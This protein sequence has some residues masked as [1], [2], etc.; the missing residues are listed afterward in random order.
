LLMGCSQRQGTPVSEEVQS[1]DQ[2]LPFDGASDKGGIFP[3]RSLVP[4]AIPAGT[5][6][7]IHLRSPLSSATSKP[8]DS[9]EA[10]LDEAIVVR[11]RI[12]APVG[13]SVTGRVLDA[14]AAD[15]R[16]EPGYMRLGLV[17]VSV[18]GQSLPIRTS[19]IFVKRGSRGRRNHSQASA[20]SAS[21]ATTAGSTITGT[22][23]P[24]A[25]VAAGTVSRGDTLTEITLAGSTIPAASASGTKISG[26]TL[27]EVSSA[28]RSPNRGVALIGAAEVTARPAAEPDYLPE[29]VDVGVGSDRRL[30]FRLAQPL[31]L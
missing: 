20:T 4:P 6:I 15:E 31:P 9:F 21:A 12:V 27:S 26:A 28:K 8:G 16:Q 10:V 13:S 24:A 1:A 5:P 18:N 19:S 30:V 17:A 22:P 25:S 3:T 14:K 11:G 23:V 7:A 29:N 2:H